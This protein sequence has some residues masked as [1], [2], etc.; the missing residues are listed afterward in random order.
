MNI[1]KH[2]LHIKREEKMSL[3][4]RAR[5]C[6]AGGVGVSAGYVV[7][8]SLTEF[9]HVWYILSSIVASI[10]NCLIDFFLQKY[11]AFH[12]KD[13]KHLRKQLNAYMLMYFA[14][15]AI[16]TEFLYILVSHF[17]VYYLFAQIVL[18]LILSAISYVATCA[19][20]SKKRKR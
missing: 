7:L 18:T 1:F 8:Y 15:F 5:F 10:I 9:A 12:N 3:L 2:G 14:L 17:H 6:I 19:I 16:N 4:Q 20:F 13:K 11:W